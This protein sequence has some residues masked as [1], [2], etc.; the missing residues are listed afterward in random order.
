MDQEPN[1]SNFSLKELYHIYSYL[2]KQKYP[3]RTK[4]L[5]QVILKKEEERNI[6]YDQDARK[7]L[8]QCQRMQK[9][10]KLKLKHSIT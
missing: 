3:E 9:N 4:R 2:N 8:D 6:I 1:Y 5:E 7:A 10:G